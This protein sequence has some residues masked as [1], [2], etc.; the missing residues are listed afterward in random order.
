MA[1]HTLYI[2]GFIVV[3]VLLFIFTI[4]NSLLFEPES[5]SEAVSR[6]IHLVASLFFPLMIVLFFCYLYN[7]TI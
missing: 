4:L 3:L 5:I 7:L 1:L 6:G 2:L